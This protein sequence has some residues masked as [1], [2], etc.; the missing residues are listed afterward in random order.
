[1]LP[2]SRGTDSSV[3]EEDYVAGS[4]TRSRPIAIGVRVKDLAL[5]DVG[6]GGS[7]LAGAREVH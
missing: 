1:M 2:T 7:H 4:G 6:E 3:G 5:P